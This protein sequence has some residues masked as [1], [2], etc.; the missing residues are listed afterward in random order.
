MIGVRNAT[1]K[2]LDAVAVMVRVGAAEGHILRRSKKELLRLI[3]DEVVVVAHDG[4]I[5]VGMAI[6]DFYSK[7]LSELRTVFIVPSYRGAGAGK[8]LINAIFEKA[9]ALK[10]KEIFTITMKEKKKYF[11]KRGFHSAPHQFKIALF[12][13]L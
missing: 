4:D 9:R 10:I 2:D 11:E 12:K 5:L 6:L 13:K 1:R 8:K 3:R 7:R